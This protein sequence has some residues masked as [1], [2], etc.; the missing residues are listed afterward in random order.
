MGRRLENLKGS[1]VRQLKY[2]DLIIHGQ[3]DGMRS[4]KE[5]L[6]G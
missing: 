1:M 6:F 2:C 4:T 5:H 3:D